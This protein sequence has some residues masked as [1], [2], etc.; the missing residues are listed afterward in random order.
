MTRRPQTYIQFSSPSA[1][2]TPSSLKLSPTPPTLEP[3]EE[4]HKMII[5]EGTLLPFCT[6]FFDLEA[7]EESRLSGDHMYMTGKS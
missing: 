4:M 2:L 1:V 5:S 6:C 7:C 3:G